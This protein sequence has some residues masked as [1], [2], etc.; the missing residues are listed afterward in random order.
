MKYNIKDLQKMLGQDYNPDYPI[1]IGK[2]T[3]MLSEVFSTKRG[4]KKTI[5]IIESSNLKEIIISIVEKDKEGMMD[6]VSRYRDLGVRKRIVKILNG[7]TQDFDVSEIE[8]EFK[9]SGDNIMTDQLFCEYCLERLYLSGLTRRCSC[10]KTST[11]SMCQHTPA[12]CLCKWYEYE[13]EEE[14]IRW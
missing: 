3:K 12:N 8:G 4:V 7:I 9:N 6:L 1:D 2:Y 10:K 5:D 14:D 13:G 11:C